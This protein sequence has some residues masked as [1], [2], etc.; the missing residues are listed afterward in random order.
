MWSWPTSLP[1]AVATFQ[2]PNQK[3]NW[4]YCRSAQAAWAKPGSIKA[5][6]IG[7]A[8]SFIRI[9]RSVSHWLRPSRPVPSSGYF[10][11]TKRRGGPLSP[12][13]FFLSLHRIEEFAV[14]FR[15]FELIQQ[16]LAGGQFVH[17]VQKLA[18]DPHLL[19]LVLRD[20]Q[21]LAAGTGLVDVDGRE[22]AAL[23]D[24]AVHVDLGVAGALE[25]LI[26]HVIHARAGLHQRG[27]D[28]GEGAA[29]LDVARGAEET[30]GAQ[31]RGGRPPH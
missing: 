20:Q 3:S 24:A 13:L 8:L 29:L 31:H 25:L 14:G 15:I 26:D 5:N 21:F 7:R 28:D 4:R 12:P 27:G 30:L 11:G 18:Q 19:Q 1:S 22:H 6:R 2:S 17:G 16:E 9:F 10:S 23:G